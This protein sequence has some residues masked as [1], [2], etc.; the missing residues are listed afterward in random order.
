MRG[1]AKLTQEVIINVQDAAVADVHRRLRLLAR[2]ERGHGEG[3]ASGLRGAYYYVEKFILT[4]REYVCCGSGTK[5][6]RGAG[7]VLT[8]PGRKSLFTWLLWRTTQTVNMRGSHSERMRFTCDTGF[9]SLL[10]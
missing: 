4:S 9:T 2:S 7:E 6:E 1:Q 10:Y 5:S 8:L 3:G